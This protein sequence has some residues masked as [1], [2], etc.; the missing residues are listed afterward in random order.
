MDETERI[1]K[2]YVNLFHKYVEG[3][4]ELKYELVRD[5][6]V[7]A[8]P[9]VL[10]V[11]HCLLMVVVVDKYTEGKHGFLKSIVLGFVMS[12]GGAI[13]NAILTATPSPVSTEGANSLV[14]IFLLCWW[15]VNCTPV[16][17]ILQIRVVFA[18]IAVVATFAR[19]RAISMTVDSVAKQ[20]PNGWVAAIIL[21][22]IGGCGGLLFLDADKK[23]RTGFNAKSTFSSPEWP[24]KS[25]FL[26][27]T[28][29]YVLSD[30]HKIIQSYVDLPHLQNADLKFALGAFLSAIA[31]LELVL[32]RSINLF[33][34]FERILVA[35]LG[36]QI[37]KP[38]EKA[39]INT[40]RSKQKTQ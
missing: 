12:F 33:Y 1:L 28:A 10:L 27:S 32:G 34:Y 36:L 6:F 35:V 14:P 7:N 26:I 31:I 20:V 23:F 37:D 40:A 8:D 22:G 5:R 17:K 11:A 18:P 16:K 15:L 29:Y 30:P 39:S 25:A 19:I 21:G 13:I 38:R 9:T 24:I 4:P 2:S 3:L